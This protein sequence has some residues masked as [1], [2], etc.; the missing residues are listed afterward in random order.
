MAPRRKRRRMLP[1]KKAS[2]LSKT[3]NEYS[4]MTL[5]GIDSECKLSGPNNRVC[6]TRTRKLQKKQMILQ[7]DIEETLKSIGLYGDSY[8]KDVQIRGI[9]KTLKDAKV[10]T[11]V[12]CCVCKEWYFLSDIKDV[13]EIPSKN[14]IQFNTILNI[15]FVL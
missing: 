5:S 8:S 4:G 11:Y 14:I 9:L 3:V 15:N 2:L 1:V 13:Q 10:G 6:E 7:E 12:M